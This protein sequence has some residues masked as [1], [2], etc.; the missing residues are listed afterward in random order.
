MAEIDGNIEDWM[1]LQW[2]QVGML[3]QY[4]DKISLLA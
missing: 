3:N 4:E 2:K 1:Y